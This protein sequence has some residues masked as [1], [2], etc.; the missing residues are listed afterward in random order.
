M[1]KENFGRIYADSCKELGGASIKLSGFCSIYDKS[2]D[3][4]AMIVYHHRGQYKWENITGVAEGYKCRSFYILIQCTDDW[5]ATCFRRAQKGYVH[6][7]L[8]KE[9][10]GC[11]HE[12]GLTCCGGFAIMKG[13]PK[14]SSTW[15]NHQSSYET[16]LSWKSDGSK[17]LSIAEKKLVNLGIR[18]WKKHG[19]HAPGRIVPITPYMDKKLKDEC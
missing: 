10:F 16:S 3:Y 5:D 1:G 18:A 6:D 4:A 14:Y 9:M 12:A 7:H 17:E 8:Y 11:S 15:L 19:R 13:K 2:K